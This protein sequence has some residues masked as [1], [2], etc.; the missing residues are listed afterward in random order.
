[1]HKFEESDVFGHRRPD[2]ITSTTQCGPKEK[3]VQSVEV[4]IYPSDYFLRN[5]HYITIYLFISYLNIQCIDKLS[6]RGIGY[7]PVQFYNVPT[8]KNI[9][10]HCM[11]EWVGKRTLSKL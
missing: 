5:E 1:M 9:A 7:V 4:T 8:K 2:E 11:N 10:E 3:L 6:C